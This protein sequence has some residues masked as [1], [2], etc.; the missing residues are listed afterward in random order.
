[1]SKTHMTEAEK[2]RIREAVTS[3]RPVDMLKDIFKMQEELDSYI[4]EKHGDKVPQN[5]S[6]WVIKTTVAME[7]EIDEVR[8]EVNWKFW[9]PEKEIDM[10]KL[11]EEVIDLWHF[12]VQLSQRVGLTPEQVFEVYKG[13]REENFARQ[14]GTSTEKDYRGGN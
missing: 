7:S 11:Q 5:L 6:D 1:M 10:E 3:E 12:L 8:A 9:K 13:K 2:Q 4:I 14:N